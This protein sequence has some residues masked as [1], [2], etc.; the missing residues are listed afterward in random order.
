MRFYWKTWGKENISYLWYLLVSKKKNVIN[1][2][3][4]VYYLILC[5]KFLR[6]VAFLV[7]AQFTRFWVKLWIEK[8]C[9]CK[10]IIF[11]MCCEA[12]QWRVRYQWGLSRL[13]LKTKH[14][15][16]GNFYNPLISCSILDLF[17]GHCLFSTFKIKFNSKYMTLQLSSVL[18]QNICIVFSSFSSSD[19]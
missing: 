17:I 11:S 8:I 13:V 5:N 19:L 6:L 4:N 3:K 10:Q 15:I 14:N 16:N 2:Y 18:I 9:S 1:A 7:L 12:S